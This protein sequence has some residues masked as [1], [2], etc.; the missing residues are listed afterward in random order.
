M[1]DASPHVA[2]SRRPAER[3]IERTIFASRWLAAPIYLLLAAS[4]ILILGA[5]LKKAAALTFHAIHAGS[6]ETII[7]ILSLIDLSLMANLVLMVVLA[8]YENFVSR[9][10]L[11]AHRD[12]PDWMDHVG[13]S[14]LKLKLMTSIVAIS[15]IHVLE[16]FMHVDTV[17]D[18]ELAWSVGI[19]MMFVLSGL[20]LAWMDR[21]SGAGHEP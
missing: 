5:F 9:F 15:A 16:N 14:Q 17:S 3:L 6:D 10:D 1:T 21:A 11:A 20:L 7:G 12:R 8:G 19:H 4:L 13:L 18:R 2:A